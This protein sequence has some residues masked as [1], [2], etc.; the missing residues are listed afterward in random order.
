MTEH[1]ERQ[2]QSLRMDGKGYKVIASATGL[3]RDIVRN[4]CKSHG[5]EGPASEFTMNM[6]ERIG[7]G[8]ACRNCGKPL[9]QPRTGRR[10]Q[11]C[12]DKCSRHWWAAHPEQSAHSAQATYHGTCACCGQ[13]FQ[14]YGNP[15]RKY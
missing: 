8:L 14:S 10:R 1:Q 15:N 9:E 12:S 6:K 7:K 5:L 2:I 4:Y 13:P 3:S 11:F